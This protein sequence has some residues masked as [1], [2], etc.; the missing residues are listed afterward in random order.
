VLCRTVLSPSQ[1]ISPR[2]PEASLT[3]NSLDYQCGTL[4]Q[5]SCGADEGQGTPA[6]AP[7]TTG[8]CYTRITWVTAAACPESPDIGADCRVQNDASG[9]AFDLNKLKKL[10]DISV[11]NL[12][13]G[14][15]LS[16]AACRAVTG[17]TC[18]SGGVG[19]CAGNTNWGQFSD[20]LVYDGGQLA[21]QYVSA[22]CCT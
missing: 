9:L 3:G 12:P 20:A 10:Q 6:V 16:V 22:P 13:G 2:Y 17:S 15:S 7:A 8:S 11:P 18:G 14:G 19:A 21:L 1:R 4:I 5:F